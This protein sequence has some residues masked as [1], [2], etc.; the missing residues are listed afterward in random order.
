MA[1]ALLESDLAALRSGDWELQPWF[2]DSAV[3]CA[4]RLLLRPAF[5][6]VVNPAQLTPLI[7]HNVH[8]VATG[9]PAF[10]AFR[11]NFIPFM[12]SKA[13]VTRGT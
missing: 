3:A 13:Q 5:L 4:I 2:T 10:D 7:K 6:L 1:L 9:R 8:Y 12:V 11:N